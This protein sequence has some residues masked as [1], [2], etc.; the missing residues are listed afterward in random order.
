MR[1]MNLVEDV[2]EFIYRAEAYGEDCYEEA[3]Q[4]CWERAPIRQRAEYLDR[5]R[6]V[7]AI[8]H[9]HLEHLGVRS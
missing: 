1:R 3:A 4:G 5:A 2:A 7:L 9:G 8:V 6:S